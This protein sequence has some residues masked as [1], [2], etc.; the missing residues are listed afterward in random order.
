MITVLKGTSPQI[1]PNRGNDKG[2]IIHASELFSIVLIL[3]LI[4]FCIPGFLLFLKIVLKT[5]FQMRFQIV[6]YKI[7][8][9]KLK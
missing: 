1:D 5:L 4:E 6:L 2:I 3:W 7:G 9:S 8:F